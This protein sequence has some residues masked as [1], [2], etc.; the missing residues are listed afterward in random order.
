MAVRSGIWRVASY[1]SFLILLAPFVLIGCAIEL[2]RAPNI[3]WR[4]FWLASLMGGGLMLAQF[5][6]HNF[7]SFALYFP[8]LIWADRALR[9]LVAQRR[10]ALMGLSLAL[11]LAYAPVKAQLIA[12]LPPGGDFDYALTRELFTDMA[13]KCR[14]HPGAVLATNN[15]GHYVRFHTDCG[16]LT[17]NFITTKQDEE[18]LREGVRLF[19]L[20]PREF[21]ADNRMFR[22][23]FVHLEGLFEKKNGRGIS[24]P[25]SEV[26]AANP[27]L[28][29]ELVLSNPSDLPSS[30][31]LIRELKFEGADGHPYARL[32]A[33]DAVQR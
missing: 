5:R 30:F 11:L 16:V 14:E 2:F 19:S 17:N 1:Y 7:G 20:T 29:R 31:H 4:Y 8:I 26:A 27:R 12:S 32:F 6:F 23:V 9:P 13:D 25:L 10:T 18:S 24:K 33:V 15:D 3:S 28:V 21:A 22:Y